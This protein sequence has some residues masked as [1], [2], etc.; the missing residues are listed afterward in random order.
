MTAQSTVGTGTTFTVSV[1][2]QL[3]GGEGAPAGAAD[4]SSLRRE[5]REEAEGFTRAADEPARPAAEGAP[6]III[7]D[8]NADLRGYLT[9]L[10]AGRY[11]VEAVADG[12]ALLERVRAALPD[13]VVA[14][15]MMPRLDGF[16]V[17]RALRDDPRTAH[18]PIVLL[19]AR[20]GEEATVDALRSGADDYVVKPFVAADLVARIDALLRRTLGRETARGDEGDER[21]A[22]REAELLSTAADRF[23]AAVDTAAV[24][25]AITSVLTPAYADWC[26]VT[27]PREDG[28]LAS[29]SLLHAE[30][31]K[32]ELGTMLEQEY[33]QHLGD[34]SLLAGVFAG[35]EPLLLEDV[36]D[37]LLR[38]AARDLR[39]YTIL[40]TLSLRSAIVVPVV[41][42]G[43]AVAAITAVRAEASARFTQHDRDF[44]LRLAAR[45]ALA[46]ES[47]RVYERERTIASTLQRALLP[48]TL[49]SV[50]GL[51]FSA[52]YTPAAQESLIGGD[53]YDAFATGDGFVILS[54]G[55]VVGHGIE[56]ATVMAALRQAVRGFAVEN[57]DP[58]AILTRLN[59]LL[60]VDQP[61]RLATALVARLDPR[62]LD[63]T[64]A[65]AGHYGPL[66]LSA[67]HAAHEI[68]P[69]DGMILG[70]DETQFAARRY[71]LQP[72]DLLALFTDGY[73]ENERD[74]DFG[75]TRLAAALRLASDAPNP[76]ARVHL[77][78]F[79]SVPP[80]D[81]AALLTVCAD[82]ALPSLSLRVLAVP[83][84]I[85][86]VRTALRRFLAGT[87]LSEERRE[88]MLVAAG[89]ALINVIEHAYEPGPG[90]ALL[91]AIQQSGGTVIEIEDFGGWRPASDE[92]V[93]RGYGLPLMHAFADGVEIERTAGG[94][95]VRL[96]AALA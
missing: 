19:S 68:L 27:V 4:T 84:K 57:S 62:T 35:N 12:A 20:A 26:S 10:L 79:G 69:V 85:G 88:E 25:R 94:T 72:G 92:Q 96:T 22:R 24:A 90:E 74:T 7:A 58:A 13:L 50:P 15:V 52:S 83:E 63:L 43:T 48:G 54:I 23:I 47:A 89:E 91:T 45:A 36:T 61:G 16:A 39:H 56:A 64:V 5:Y 21:A 53:W 9:R 3:A 31:A 11:A 77:D 14:D 34:G 59:H 82:A 75:E 8:D 41:L 46:F 87:A 76:A 37:E 33:P 70:V 86:G 60:L 73:V 49:P 6:R 95:R 81:D 40:A 93:Q 51:R 32:A 38:A 2:L 66:R 55:D 80:R 30:P 67:D 1:P 18:V 71:A 42:G 78:V 17:L 65:S 44:M 28:R 29:L